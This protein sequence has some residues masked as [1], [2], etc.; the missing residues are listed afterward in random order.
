MI[1]FIKGD[2]FSSEVQ[3]I[4]NTVNC[5]GVMGKGIAL[6]YKKR[7]PRMF[8]IYKKICDNKLLDIGKL[9]LYKS[10]EK[11]ILNFPTKTDWRNP[12][13]IKNIEEGLKKFVNTYKEKGITSIAFPHLGCQ[14]GGLDFESQVKPLMIKY[15]EDLDLEIEIYEYL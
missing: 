9:F 12:S 3:T 10:E 4:V 8:S 6:K 1:K 2:F 7:Y 11:W 5:V 14:N 15:L 13:E